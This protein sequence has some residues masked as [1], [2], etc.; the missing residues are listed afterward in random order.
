VVTE[1]ASL[2]AEHGPYAGVF[3]GLGGAVMGKMVGTLA[4]D[5]V[6]VSYGGTAGYTTE[7]G[8]FQL[9]R[10]SSIYGFS[11]Y[12]ETD[13]EAGGV[14]LGRLM[15]MLEA[16]HIEVEIGYRGSWEDIASAAEALIAREFPGKGVLTLE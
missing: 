1:E 6:L 11:L 13:E 4:P 2:M 10:R 5:G 8:V 15:T 14:S 9:P 7:F 3:E 16:G 12:Q